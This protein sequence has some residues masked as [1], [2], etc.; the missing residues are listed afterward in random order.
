MPCLPQF[1]RILGDGWPELE[2]NDP[3]GAGWE[4]AGGS[5]QHVLGEINLQSSGSLCGPERSPWQRARAGAFTAAIAA[6]PEPGTL[7]LNH[8]SDH[9]G[10]SVGWHAVAPRAHKHVLNV[11][12]MLTPLLR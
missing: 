11:R 8:R 10:N 5:N 2:Q 1:R 4:E 6:L 9:F 12:R 3:F 7:P